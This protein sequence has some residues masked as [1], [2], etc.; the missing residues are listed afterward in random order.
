MS[1][2]LDKQ[3]IRSVIKEMIENEEITLRLDT[4]MYQFDY[5]NN[6]TNAEDVK[7]IMD[8][9]NIIMEVSDD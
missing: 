2:T 3:L 1:E 8:D 5:D 7:N 9:V 6:I 4:T